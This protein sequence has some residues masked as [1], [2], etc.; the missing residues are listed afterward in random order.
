EARIGLRLNPNESHLYFHLGSALLYL[1]R[2]DEARDVIMQ[3]QSRNLDHP[4]YRSTLYAVALVTGNKDQTQ[5]QLDQIRKMEGEKAAPTMQIR[6]SVLSGRWEEAQDLY[7]RQ[8]S[9]SGQS[10]SSKSSALPAAATVNQTLFGFCD[11]TSENVRDTFSVTR[12][13]SGSE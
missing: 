10:P 12:I 3:G 7:H 2:F 13:S 8:A 5:Q 11:P 4:Y 6:S 1:N 9:L